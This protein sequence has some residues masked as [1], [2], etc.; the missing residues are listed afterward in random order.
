MLA[1]YMHIPPALDLRSGGSRNEYCCFIY[2][3]KMEGL[4]YKENTICLQIWS[5]GNSSAQIY[6]KR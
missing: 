3:K 6:R 1:E 5:G 2:G 4:F